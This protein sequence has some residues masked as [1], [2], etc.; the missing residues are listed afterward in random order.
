MFSIS[1]FPLSAVLFFIFPCYPF[2]PPLS[3]LPSVSSLLVSSF[4]LYFM[5]DSEEDGDK[6]DK[7]MWYYSTKVNTASTP[8]LAL[9]LWSDES[10]LYEGFLI[11][12]AFL[13]VL[14]LGPSFFICVSL[15]Q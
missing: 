11:L 14:L 1:T 12:N 3:L 7:T 9:C 15:H 10:L 4:L 5:L 2:T 6:E 8:H 13:Q